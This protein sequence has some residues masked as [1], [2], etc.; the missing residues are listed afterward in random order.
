MA[1]KVLTKDVVLGMLADE[2]KPL[3]IAQVVSFVEEQ[4]K[5]LENL[6]EEKLLVDELEERN[7]SL[8]EQLVALDEENRHLKETAEGADNLVSVES[9]LELL[10]IKK[11]ESAALPKRVEQLL[12]DRESLQARLDECLA[13][14]KQAKVALKEAEGRLKTLEQEKA[15]EEETRETK[16]AEAA[17][18]FAA[19]KEQHDAFRQDYINA[20]AG[21]MEILGKTQEEVER[22]RKLSESL[23]FEDL[24][25]RADEVSVR[26]NE[27]FT[28]ERITTDTLQPGEQLWSELSS[29][30]TMG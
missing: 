24:K 9:V 11:S 26:Y 23:G 5:K 29:Y 6:R 16:E 7:K 19:L 15:V 30:R 27:V 3:D 2:K 25:L 20:V 28:V 13:E 21:K 22:F 10:G 4:A 12:A 18:Q 14:C 17:K 8:E 1:K